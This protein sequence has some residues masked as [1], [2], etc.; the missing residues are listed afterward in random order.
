MFAPG[1]IAT[2]LRLLDGEQQSPTNSPQCHVIGCQNRVTHSHYSKDDPYG[3]QYFCTLH[4][5]EH[6]L[7]DKTYIVEPW[8]TE[9][10]EETIA[11]LTGF[12]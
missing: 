10:S 7:P 11:K 6:M 2:S 8:K 9:L 12:S 4:T 3:L 5:V 1:V